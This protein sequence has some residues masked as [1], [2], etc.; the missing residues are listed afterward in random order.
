MGNILHEYIKNYDDFLFTIKLLTSN[1]SK[2]LRKTFEDAS[3]I[4]YSNETLL[5]YLFKQRNKEIK[6]INKYSD[7]LNVEINNYQIEI[8]EEDLNNLLHFIKNEHFEDN[9]NKELK[10]GNGKYL[11]QYFNAINISIWIAFYNSKIEELKGVS[12]VG[13]QINT[14]NDLVFNNEISETF[15]N[16]IVEN[17][18]KEEPNKVTALRFVFSEMWYKTLEKETPYKIISSQPYFA[19]EYWNKNYLNLLELHP[20]NPK[21]KKD[22]FTDYYHKRFAYFLTEFQGG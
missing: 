22:N 3:I 16:Y 18:L 1:T 9:E 7:V 17:W 2:L 19:R 14:F 6:K 15:F 11:T 21:L 13:N 20:K 5:K 4:N 12:I 10:E 8:I